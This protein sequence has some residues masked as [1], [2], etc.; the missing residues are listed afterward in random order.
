MIE[1]HHPVDSVLGEPR[2]SYLLAQLSG[3]GNLPPVDFSDKDTQTRL[4]EIAKRQQHFATEYYK[5]KRQVEDED[6]KLKISAL[7]KTPEE[8][9]FLATLVSKVY[10]HYPAP[11]GLCSK[12]HK[13]PTC[14]ACWP[15]YNA[16]ITSHL[17]VRD[18][19]MEQIYDI[20]GMKMEY[21]NSWTKVLEKL[22]QM[23]K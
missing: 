5:L 9:E 16:L 20:V 11:C 3:E 2:I 12:I 4:V 10:P 21:P 22:K 18:N 6:R 17:I 23:I 1:T 13:D 7:E 15:D 8:F 14:G 19:M